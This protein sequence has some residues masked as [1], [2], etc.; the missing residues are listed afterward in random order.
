MGWDNQNVHELLEKARTGDKECQN[1]LF[2]KLRDRFEFIAVQRVGCEMGPDLAQKACL[3]VLQKYKTETFHISFESWAYGILNNIIRQTFDRM[4]IEMKVFDGGEQPEAADAS[5]V[6]PQ[7]RMSLEQCLKELS[8]QSPKYFRILSL[9]VE[10]YT[11]KEIAE[12][13]E[14]RPATLDTYISR[15]RIMLFQCIEKKR[16]RLIK[17]KSN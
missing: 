10:G 4:G 14:T 15:C 13:T 12:L 16:K 5:S 1:I 11:R 7:L 9:L 2:A 17:T 3:V 8:I 6:D